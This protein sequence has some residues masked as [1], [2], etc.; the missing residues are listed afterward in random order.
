MAQKTICDFC[1]KNEA[2]KNIRMQEK[3]EVVCFGHGFAFPETRWEEIDI[4]D[5]C[6][7]KFFNKDKKNHSDKETDKLAEYKERVLNYFEKVSYQLY[8]FG[9]RIY[10]MRLVRDILDER[11]DRFDTDL[12]SYNKYNTSK[13][14]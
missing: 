1:N 10:F 14:T 3:R 5:E 8:P 4:C 7:K 6:Y 11:Y 2:N 9:E 13:E 12:L